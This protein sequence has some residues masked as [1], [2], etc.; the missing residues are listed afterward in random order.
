MF[1]RSIFRSLIRSFKA[2][3]EFLEFIVLEDPT[4]HEVIQWARGTETVY[5]NK[6]QAKK[7]T[8]LQKEKKSQKADENVFSRVAYKYSKKAMEEF[9]RDSR[10]CFIFRRYAQ[11]IKQIGYNSCINRRD[12]KR[13]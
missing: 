12:N 13:N 3:A 1:R 11:L 7:M 9:F 4:F 2:D 5:E 6:T 10:L 8:K